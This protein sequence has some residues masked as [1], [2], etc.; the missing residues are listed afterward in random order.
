[1]SPM[2]R[3]NTGATW[4]PYPIDVILI[5][6]GDQERERSI[7]KDLRNQNQHREWFFLNDYSVAYLENLKDEDVRHGTDEEIEGD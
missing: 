5:I 4:C 1:M 6:E 3:I 2:T 7:Q